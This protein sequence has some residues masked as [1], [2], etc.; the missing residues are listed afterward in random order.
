VRHTPPQVRDAKVTFI[1][2]SVCGRKMGKK[3]GVQV[4]L[5][6]VCEDPICNYQDET[7]VNESRDALVV[8]AVLGGIP[9]S[10]IAAFSGISRQRVYQILDTWK[11][12]V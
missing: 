7:S 5:G 6:A 10:R 1:F 12:G 8:A 2:C 9:V 11:D 4:V 3:P